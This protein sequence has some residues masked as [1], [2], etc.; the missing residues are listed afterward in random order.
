MAKTK[1]PKSQAVTEY[2]N[3][4]DVIP[5]GEI[6]DYLKSEKSTGLE[7]LGAGDFKVPRIKLLH[8]LSP[9]IQEFQGQA[10]PGEFWHEGANR[11]IG[12]EFIFVPINAG[13]RVILWK[14]R[15]DGGGMLAFSRDAV[16]WASGGDKT[17]EVMLDRKSKKRVKW[18]TGKNVPY[19]KLLEWGS[20]NPEDDQSPPAATLTYEYLCYLPRFPELSPCLYGVFKTALPAGKQLNSSL[21]M[22][23]KPTASVA[24]KC[25]SV[26][27]S[28]G[29]D[30]YLT[31]KFQ[32]MGFVPEETF[33]VCADLGEKH[34]NYQADYSQTEL[35]NEPAQ[36]TVA[37]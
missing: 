19:S 6:P 23:R 33:R 14:P 10:I 5:F 16:N 32:T 26:E 21:L 8:P 3:N 24:V 36:S 2:S 12:K 11:S 1:S 7:T 13:K 25:W 29:T 22:L 4:T 15:D 17:F 28:N 35:E 37:Y 30:T 20:S 9:E 31:P 18:Q 34:K 27:T